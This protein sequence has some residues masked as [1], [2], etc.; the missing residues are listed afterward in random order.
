MIDRHLVLR[1]NASAILILASQG[2]AISRD[3]AT[4]EI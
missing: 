3:F 4:V 2:T 1:W